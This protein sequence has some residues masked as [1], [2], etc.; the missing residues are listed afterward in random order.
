M[1]KLESVLYPAHRMAVEAMPVTERAVP[2]IA[3]DDADGART[4]AARDVAAGAD[5]VALKPGLVT[6]DLVA[7]VAESVDRP[8]ITFFTADEHALFTSADDS[9]DLAAAERETFSAARRAGADLLISY[10]ARSATTE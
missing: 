10:G 5:A 9:R 8:V 1:V 7:P 2:L 6:L 3:V 4:R